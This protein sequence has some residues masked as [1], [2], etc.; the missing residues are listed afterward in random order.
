[1]IGGLAMLAIAA[2]GLSAGALLAEGAIL[3]P[4]WRS[5][6]ARSFLAWYREH[7]GLLLRFFA[8]L[9]IAAALLPALAAAVGWLGGSAG[10]PLLAVSAAL[11]LLVLAAFPA[12]FQRANASF[13]DQSIAVDQVPDE[14]RRWSRW[15]WGRACVATLAFL[16]AILALLQ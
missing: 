13:A 16:L 2:L 9:E 1:M 5:L 15:H 3:V 14:L 11:A 8:P 12:Y 10:A 7:A 6:P 4:F